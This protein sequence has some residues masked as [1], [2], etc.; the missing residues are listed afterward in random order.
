[1]RTVFEER[2]TLTWNEQA[3]LTIAYEA[4]GEKDASIRAAE[5][6]V[7][8]DGAGTSGAV[9]SQFYHAPNARVLLARILAHFDEHARAIEILEKELP[10]PSWLSV[11]LLE[12]D[13]I[14][15]PLR[16]HPRFQA[17]LEKYRD[18]GVPR[19]R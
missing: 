10:A 13:P 3:T 2:Q 1:V 6:L 11:P 5:A 19:R 16:D 8:L 18:D 12:I 4:L 7:S 15:D 14:W 17:L 9:G